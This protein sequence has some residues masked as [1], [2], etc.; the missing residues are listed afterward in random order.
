ME[1]SPEPGPARS[2]APVEETRP[3]KHAD[4]DLAA[5]ENEQEKQ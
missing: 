1:S 4:A 2:Q 3:V 5:P